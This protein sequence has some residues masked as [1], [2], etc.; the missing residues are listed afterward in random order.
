MNY[1]EKFGFVIYA[2]AILAILGAF[3]GWPSN[4]I[5]MMT[6][7][8][9]SIGIGI[10]LSGISGEFV[11]LLSGDIFK[12]IFLFVPIGPFDFSISLFPFT[13]LIVKLWLFS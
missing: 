2:I 5:S 10:V 8:L 4:T 1:V 7:W 11:E 12:K 3:L 13:T 6:E 9:I